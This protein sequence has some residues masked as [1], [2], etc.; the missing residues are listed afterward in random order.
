MKSQLSGIAMILLTGATALAMARPSKLHIRQTSDLCTEEGFDVPLCCT[1]I[2][3]ED[4]DVL[5]C[6]V[7]GTTSSIEEWD[8]S[9]EGDSEGPA[10]C[11]V[12]G[13][14]LELSDC[15]RL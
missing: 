14:T 8:E 1:Y 13:E 9:C 4:D 15:I 12:N 7:P 3:L 2:Q 6:S 10:C 11:I 5:S